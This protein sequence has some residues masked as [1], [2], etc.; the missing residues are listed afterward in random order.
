V[1]KFS[2]TVSRTDK[3]QE[4]TVPQKMSVV[5]CGNEKPTKSSTDSEKYWQTY[6][7]GPNAT[8]DRAGLIFK[9]PVLHVVRPDC[10]ACVSD[11]DLM[12]EA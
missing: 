10:F 2:S 12:V 5:E 8:A 1:F 7:K 4:R 6:C 11:H 9:F 3:K